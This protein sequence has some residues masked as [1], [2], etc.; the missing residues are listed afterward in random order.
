[1]R[2]R[3][4]PGR[5][6]GPRS[7]RFNRLMAK[8]KVVSLD[9]F[10]TA[11]R[12]KLGSPRDLFHIMEAML[13]P[14]LK[15][16]MPA[17]GRC[18]VDAEAQAWRRMR[19]R[20][21]TGQ[22]T[23]S[24]IYTVLKEAYALTPEDVLF[25]YNLEIETEIR[26]T[27]ADP[28]FL[29]LQTDARAM[30]L[31]VIFLSDMYLPSV[32]LRTM[33]RHHGFLN[34]AVFV[35]SEEGGNKASGRL[36][37][38]VEKKMGHPSADFLHFGDRYYA[39]YLSP[40][41]MGWRAVHVKN[42]EDESLR[43]PPLSSP[44]RILFSVTQELIRKKKIERPMQSLEGE[45]QAE[46]WNDFGYDV[47]GPIYFYFL[48]WLCH[49]SQRDGIK[50][51]LLCSRDGFPLLP[52]FTILREKWNI[53]LETRYFFASRRMFNLAAI[54]EI[55]PAD[56][57]FLLMPNPGLKLRDFVERLGLDASAQAPTL[58]QLGFASLDQQVVHSGFGR[59]ID[60]AFRKWLEKWL[61]LSR[62]EILMHAGEERKLVLEY[63][64]EMQ[65]A[66]R[67]TAVVD[68]GWKATVCLSISRLMGEIDS[69]SP[70]KTYFFG[71]YEHARQLLE[72]GTRLRSF[73]FH[74]GKP[75][76]QKQIVAG[77]EGIVE[78]LFHAP[79]GSLRGL[80]RG[81]RGLEPVYGDCEYDEATLCFLGRMTA[82]AHH[83]VADMADLLP[84]GDAFNPAPEVVGNILA[85]LTRCPTRT[86]GRNLGGIAYRASYG[87]RGAIQPLAQVEEGIPYSFRADL[88][89]Y[90]QAPWKEGYF[91]QVSSLRRLVLGIAA[92][93]HSVSIAIT[94]KTLLASLRWALFKREKDAS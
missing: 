3:E 31:K 44:E 42:K 21:K 65:P 16:V 25:L 47:V 87:D 90:E 59:F 45:D 4:E 80:K 13:A 11:L 6:A 41:L 32:C 23:L 69:G 48:H 55:K 58:L 54:R 51:L 19:L 52:G 79:H 14:R 64:A 53:E 10:D 67:D 75:L 94:S 60:P 24:D 40:R 73:L 72:R 5:S 77:H 43:T 35:S 61:N 92:F 76:K 81:V 34:P 74:L 86:E 63:L 50:R 2:A 22:I 85:R 12:R 66:R 46:F 38:I 36:F 83:F 71:T 27:Y 70:L 89:A 93:A 57:D 1:V 62:E 82:G 17:F 30:G 84:P 56:I 7:N 18:R 9:I 26:F 20:Q 78:M 68:V 49:Q 28:A 37:R 29:R 39:D 8:A 33:L 88:V 91:V 15:A